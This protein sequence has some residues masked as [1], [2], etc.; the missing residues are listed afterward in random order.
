M[1][2]DFESI[3]HIL[4]C[5]VSHCDLVMIGDSLVSTDAA[6]RRQYPIVDSIPCLIAEES[7]VLSEEAWLRL[8]EQSQRI[9]K[10]GGPKN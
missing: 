6:N 5:P 3:R 9:P 4:A 8:M 2:F 10:V 1:E 7:T